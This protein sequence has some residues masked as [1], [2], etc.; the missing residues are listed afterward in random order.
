MDK[1]LLGSQVVVSNSK[2]L[3]WPLN[4][5]NLAEKMHKRPNYEPFH[6]TTKLYKFCGCTSTQKKRTDLESHPDAF[7]D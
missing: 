2:T 4:K 6:H 7:N 5:S 1:W 3:H